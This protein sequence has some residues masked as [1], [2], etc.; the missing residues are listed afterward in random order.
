MYNK[1]NYRKAQTV[2]LNVS[3]KSNFYT[4]Q[5]GSKILY[6]FEEKENG[7]VLVHNHYE[8]IVN[9]EYDSLLV[10]LTNIK[11]IVTVIKANLEID[12]LK[13]TYKRIYKHWIDVFQRLMMF[14]SLC[15]QELV[16][17]RDEK[18]LEVLLKKEGIL[19]EDS[20]NDVLGLCK[21]VSSTILS[22]LFQDTEVFVELDADYNVI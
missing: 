18:S 4:I 5:D 14:D 13:K 19:F 11:H 15:F 9:C 20:F 22:D 21:Y 2:A 1:V 3:E 6:L 7:N 16:E 8:N 17:E 12:T 10:D